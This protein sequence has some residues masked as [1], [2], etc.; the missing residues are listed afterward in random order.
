VLLTEAAARS[1]ELGQWVEVS[2]E[3]TVAA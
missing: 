3:A 2:D 1:A